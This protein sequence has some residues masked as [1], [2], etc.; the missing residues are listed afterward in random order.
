MGDADVVL[1]SL[2]ADNLKRQYQEAVSEL[3]RQHQEIVGDLKR[4]LA[5][6]RFLAFHQSNAYDDDRLDKTSY[7]A[8]ISIKEGSLV[9]ADALDFL[10]K[11]EA[12]NLIVYFEI[13]FDNMVTCITQAVNAFPEYDDGFCDMLMSRLAE[14]TNF[15]FRG[16]PY[17]KSRV[18]DDLEVLQTCKKLFS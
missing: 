11:W 5:I 1:V 7:L 15:D 18:Q 2:V 12:E 4:E 6:E 17:Y 16:D 3:K 14:F 13:S 8:K 9:W 10:I